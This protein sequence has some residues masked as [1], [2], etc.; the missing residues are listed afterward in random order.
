MQ[1]ELLKEKSTQS[2][3]GHVNAFYSTLS[4]HID[5]KYAADEQWPLKTDF[6]VEVV[7]SWEYM[8]RQHC[9]QRKDFFLIENGRFGQQKMFSWQL[10]ETK[11]LSILLRSNY[12]Q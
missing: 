8:I 4:I 2:F 12:N 1:C 9:R 11:T 6:K 5:A 7:H 3:D 10:I